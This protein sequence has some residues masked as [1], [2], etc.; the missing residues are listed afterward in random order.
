MIYT[1]INSPVLCLRNRLLSGPTALN[2][3]SFWRPTL[4]LSVMP[5]LADVPKVDVDISGANQRPKT[6]SVRYR[7][8][9]AHQK[10]SVRGGR[11]SRTVWDL[12]RL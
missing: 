2:A 11:L 4:A 12:D 3:Q 6:W 9:P 5:T 7:F 1:C 10:A 8:G